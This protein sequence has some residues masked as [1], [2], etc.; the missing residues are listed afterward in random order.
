MPT[1]APIGHVFYSEPRAVQIRDTP[2]EDIKHL[3]SAISGTVNLVAVTVED[4]NKILAG[5]SEIMTAI[6]LKVEEII[7]RE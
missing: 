6:N 7:G 4:R 2:E 1:P 3:A 5:W